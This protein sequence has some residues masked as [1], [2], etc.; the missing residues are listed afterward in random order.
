[1]SDIS[2]RLIEVLKDIYADAVDAIGGMQKKQTHLSTTVEVNRLTRTAL[3]CYR[4]NVTTDDAEKSKLL[5]LIEKSSSM[6]K[7]LS[8]AFDELEGQLVE[9][10]KGLADLEEDLRTVDPNFG[11][12]L[13]PELPFTN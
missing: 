5:E 8:E 6:E 2:P 9:M 1:V 4:D 13:G 7:A 3:E 12:D 10:R 11:K